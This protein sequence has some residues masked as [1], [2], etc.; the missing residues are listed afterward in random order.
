MAAPE[1][2]VKAGAALIA[3]RFTA[4]DLA[5]QI[6]QAISAIETAADELTATHDLKHMQAGSAYVKLRKAQAAVG[7]IMDAH[8][9]IRLEI[10]AAGIP[11]PTDAQIL[12]VIGTNRKAASIR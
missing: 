8:N 3:A 4:I 11:E 6:D 9:D 2:V 12:A 5:E 1:S 7:L 10:K